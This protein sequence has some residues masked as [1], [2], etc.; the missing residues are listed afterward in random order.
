MKK[1]IQL[2]NNKLLFLIF[3]MMY[4]TDA[5]LVNTNI[6]RIWARLA[7]MGIILLALFFVPKARYSSND[8]T[9]LG[10]FTIGI[11]ASMLV[12]EGFDVNSIQRIILLWCS[13]AIVTI[14]DYDR[15]MITYIKIMR[16]IAVF[17]M[18]C[19]LIA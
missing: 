15:F 6:D 11:L 9:F 3:F 4:C 8:I 16:F 2:S 13:F 5:A 1:I 19:L 14:V 18:I 12:T 17:S 10:L 7:W